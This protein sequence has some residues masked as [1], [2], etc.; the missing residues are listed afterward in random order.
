[1]LALSASAVLSISGL[2]SAADGTDAVSGA[3]A[4]Y[5]GKHGSDRMS[6]FSDELGL[7]AQQKTDIGIITSDYGERLRD[8]AK[9]G[10]QT[11]E[12]LMEMSPDDPAYAAKTD[13]ASAL[14]ASSAAE[15]VILL[16]EMRGKLY[17][18]LT[19]EQRQL[20]RDKLDEKKRRWE[21]K[22]QQREQQPDDGAH[23]RPMEQF[24][25]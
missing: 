11:A 24:I 22:K 1:M 4:P 13:E 10:R 23:D 17:A 5:A 14:A 12:G 2:A 15:V 16:A 19:D 9:L 20:L 18:V 8:L 3:T 7:T 25:G 6:G 21:E